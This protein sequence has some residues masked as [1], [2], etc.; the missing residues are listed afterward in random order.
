LA[1]VYFQTKDFQKAIECFEK[2]Y[3]ILLNH[4]GENHPNTKQVKRDL[5]YVKQMVT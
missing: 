2:A 3:L 1:H 5:D 4:L